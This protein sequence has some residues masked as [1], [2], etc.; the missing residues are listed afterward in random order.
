MDIDLSP[1]ESTMNEMA[2]DLLIILGAPFLIA[3]IIVFLLKKL[4]LPAGIVQFIAAITML[5][6]V[7]LMFMNMNFDYN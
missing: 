2:L 1:M 6:G 7:Y 3:L 4:K 5:V